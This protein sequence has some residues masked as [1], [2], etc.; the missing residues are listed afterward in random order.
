MSEVLDNVLLIGSG[1][2][3]HALAAALVRSE[4]VRNLHAAPGNPGI[5]QIATC[6]EL[7][8]TDPAA[9]VAVAKHVDADL[10][11]IG[12]EVPLVAGAVDALEADGRPAFGPLADA[13]RLEGSKAFLKEVLA[14][15]GVPTAR[16]A[17]FTAGQEEAGFAFLETLPGL[18]VIKTDGL[19]A[20][21]GVI[22]TESMADARTAVR[23]YLSGAAF[24]D[25]G[26]TCVIEEGMTGPELSVFALT[27]GNEVFTFAPAQDH[28]RIGDGDTG[29][30]T[31]GMGAYSPVPVATAEIV[32]QVV[33]D[34]VR[35]TLAE[36]Q[37]RGI[38]YRGLL[39]AGLMLTPEGPKIIEYNVRF[40]DP[41]TQ[42]VVPR[43]ASDLALHCLESAHG[44]LVT[45]IETVP[46]AAVTVVLA[47]EG[48]P[49]SVRTGD[50][51]EGL[52]AAAALPG[53]QIFHA[54]TARS[55]Q[56]ELVTAGGRVLNVTAMAPTFDEARA[57]AYAAADLIS[58][59][60][61]QFRRDIG[62]RAGA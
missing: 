7:D 6:H 52:D 45:P 16:Y 19:A 5:A 2:R 11:V 57:R 24:G 30:N 61:M 9:V 20:G 17:A 15:G 54:G 8:V 38:T 44:A 32:E 50:V 41:E 48:Y 34:A 46:D 10:V 26:T 22:V 49:G 14:A 23:E 59:P 36:L 29:P 18:Y 31:G 51:I 33:R 55:R 60:G 47:A 40:G 56:G 27:D 39:Y 12:P 58:W 3:E 42:V 35:P 1:G 21:K 25:A 53:V 43:V 13:A 4:R 62:A 37:R 28:K